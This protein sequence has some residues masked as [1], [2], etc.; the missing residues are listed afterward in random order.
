MLVLMG[1]TI[2][3]MDAKN[4]T[5]D[6]IISVSPSHRKQIPSPINPAPPKNKRGGDINK[7]RVNNGM[8]IRFDNGATR[9]TKPNF[10]K[11]MGNVIKVTVRVVTMLETSFLKNP[12]VLFL[13]IINPLTAQPSIAKNESIRLTDAME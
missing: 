1:I 6:R 11:T 12:R 2:P 10:E 4:S 8:N 9:D 3:S 13:L 5:T 7:R